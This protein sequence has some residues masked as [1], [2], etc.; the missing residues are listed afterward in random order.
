MGEF[1]Y[2]NKKFLMSACDR[3]RLVVRVSWLPIWTS[4]HLIGKQLELFSEIESINREHINGI[5]TGIRLLHYTIRENDIEKY[6][7]SVTIDGRV[8]LVSVSGRPPQCFR[9]G[10]LGHIRSECSYNIPVVGVGPNGRRTYASAVGG[11][12]AQAPAPQ[13][14]SGGD[15]VRDSD[16]RQ[17]GDQVDPPRL[18]RRE[19]MKRAVP[20]SPGTKRWIHLRA[21]MRVERMWILIRTLL[22]GL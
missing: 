16:P 5:Q 12:R 6:P 8:G 1:I 9:C 14:L 20:G 22:M 21:R 3:R 2:N 4:N 13:K 10:C 7:Y 17:I 15:G 11:Y 18:A 19:G